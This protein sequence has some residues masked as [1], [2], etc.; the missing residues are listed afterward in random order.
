MGTN[1]RTTKIFRE[2]VIINKLIW[3]EKIENKSIMNFL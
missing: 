2:M 1:R 3:D